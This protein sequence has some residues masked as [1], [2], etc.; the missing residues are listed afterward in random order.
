[1]LAFIFIIWRLS[2]AAKVRSQL[3]ALRQAGHA[4]TLAQVEQT[5][6]PDP[7]ADNAAT[8]FSD[9]F[10]QI[11]ILNSPALAVI[12]KLSVPADSPIAPLTLA[13]SNA[14]TKL[15]ADNRAALEMLRQ[16]P[17][18]TNC[19]YP[20]DMSKGYAMLLPHLKYIKSSTQLL[21]LSAVQRSDSRDTSGALSDLEAGFRVIDSLA[22]EPLMI[23][24]L[25]RIAGRATVL[26]GLERVLNQHTLTEPQLANLAD[27]LRKE[28]DPVGMERAIEC[29]LG[30]GLSVFQSPRDAIA[31]AAYS[32]GSDGG[33]AS[34]QGGGAGAFV[35]LMKFTGFLDRDEAYY[36][37]FMSDHLE[38]ARQPYPQRL[39]TENAIEERL[40]H[41]SF[42][43]LH[44]LSGM[45]LP[46]LGKYGS[47]EA[48]AFANIRV[49]ETVVAIERCRLANHGRLPDQ[50]SDLSPSFLPDPP[51]DPFDGQPLRFT[52]IATGYEI[53]SIGMNGKDDGGVRDPSGRQN[54][55]DDVTF[56]VR[57]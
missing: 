7:G 34:S 29:E 5:Y 23:S 45:L 1:V 19:R 36:L 17:P 39:D 48:S 53:Y 31:L 11:D 50:L 16:M 22:N 46:A 47:R 41:T 24:R 32:P 38:A 44:P 6:Y 43:G 13:E 10:A 33:D 15:L 28:N 30:T 8:F 3:A 42:R 12:K 57:R 20:I 21:T 35:G 26:S 55:P 14:V 40:F 51:V 9:A 2:I 25:V 37:K 27:R 4:V 54:Q 56:T 52:K 49:A 18:S